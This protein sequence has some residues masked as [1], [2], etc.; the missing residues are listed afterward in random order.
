MPLALALGL[1]GCAG[2]DDGPAAGGDA[3]AAGSPSTGVGTGG[4]TTPAPVPVD[5]DAPLDLQTETVASGLEVPWALAVG[6]DDTLFVTERPGR[7]RVISG[8][9]LE[10]QPV[11]ELDVAAVGEGGL[12]GLA[13]HPR[14]PDTPFVY[15]YATR[16]SGGELRNVLTRHRLERG[17]PAGWRLEGET[18]L[19]D[20]IPAG[21]IHDGGRVAFGPDGRLYVTTGDTGRPELA[22]DLGSLAGKVLRL[23]AAGRPAAD[24]PVPG[25]PVFTYGHRNPQG[26]AWADDGTLYASE[27]GPSG[28]FGLCCRDEVNRLQ[29]S[30]FFGWPL[31]AADDTAAPAG[32]VEVTRDP[33]PPVANS[34]P[35]ATWAPGGLAAIASGTG[36][37]A[38]VNLLVPQLAGQQLLRLVL[39]ASGGAVAREEVALDG[40][41]R[42]RQAVAAPDGCLYLLTNNRDGRGDPAPEDDRV[43]RACPAGIEAGQPEEAGAAGAAPG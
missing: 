16:G 27:H 22:A 36:E 31:V 8:G 12:L 40:L 4:E 43:I 42:I 19:L 14:F 2:D 17:G 15:L 13:L 1:A 29:P 35:D 6:P 39:D 3:P 38:V 7:V 30:G 9:E 28:E 25:S 37:D 41:G 26:L 21:T 10:P 33:F 5:P 20:D 24:N 11:G 18:V 23:D 32:T 34:G